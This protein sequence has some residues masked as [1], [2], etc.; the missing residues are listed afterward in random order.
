MYYCTGTRVQLIVIH[1]LSLV[2]QPSASIGSFSLSDSPCQSLGSLIVSASGQDALEPLTNINYSFP[3]QHEDVNGH[4]SQ[5]RQSIKI[6]AE[7]RDS[8]RFRS[9]FVAPQLTQNWHLNGSTQELVE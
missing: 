5:S 4:V 2:R 6:E 7:T 3:S 8:R 1:P 9:K